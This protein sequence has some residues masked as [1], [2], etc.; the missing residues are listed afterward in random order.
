MVYESEE[1]SDSEN[2]D[3]NKHLLEENPNFTTASFAKFIEYFKKVEYFR[4][5]L[6]D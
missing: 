5:Q 3:Y 2:S 4:P 6:E 1:S